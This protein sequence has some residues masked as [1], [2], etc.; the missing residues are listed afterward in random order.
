M[1]ASGWEPVPLRVTTD[2]SRGGRWTSLCGG[3]RE[4][5]WTNSDAAVQR[6]RREAGPGDAFPDAGGVEE[7]LPTVR[8]TPDHGDVW[9]RRWT[10]QDNTSASA[11]SF[12]V[13]S[14]GP[15]DPGLGAAVTL[16]RTFSTTVAGL[17]VD[18]A[19]SGPP[20]VP[21]LHAV[22]ALLQLTPSARLQARPREAQVLDVP[23]P[24]HLSPVSWPAGLDRLGPDDGSATCVLLKGC[25]SAEVV[26]VDDRLSLRWS[27]DDD[28]LCSM[29][30]W[31]NLGGWPESRPYR[32]VGIEPMVGRCADHRAAGPSDLVRIGPDATFRWSL[33]IAASRRTAA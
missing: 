22:H 19:I 30:L 31:R 25:R 27:A 6:A 7:C 1:T 16:Q 14:A 23:E 9:S 28:A 5:L 24:G 20:G 4:W 18:Y 15:D 32:S 13:T 8:G 10:Q 33:T 3:G 11:V 12:P 21:F 26:D 17:Q 2:P 29:L